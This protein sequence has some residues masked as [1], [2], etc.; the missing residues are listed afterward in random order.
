MFIHHT[1]DQPTHRAF[2][3][4]HRFARRRAVRRNHHL[5]MHARAMRINGNLRHTF[6]LTICADRLTN[7]KSP[8]IEA[9]MFPSC[10]DVAFDAREEHGVS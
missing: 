4:P 10:H 7:H 6:C 3:I 9:R 8:T 5:L 2:L 1:D